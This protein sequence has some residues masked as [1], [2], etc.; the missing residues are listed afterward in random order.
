VYLEMKVKKAGIT[1]VDMESGEQW[2][3]FTGKNVLI[4]P[5]LITI[6]IVGPI[7]FPLLLSLISPLPVTALYVAEGF[8]AVFSIWYIATILVVSNTMG[9]LVVKLFQAYFWIAR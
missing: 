9:W 3:F 2:I 1:G 5:F 8:Y 6:T 7:I 4:M